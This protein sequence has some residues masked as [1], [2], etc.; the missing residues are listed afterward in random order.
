MPNFMVLFERHP[1]SPL[2]DFPQSIEKAV[3]LCALCGLATLVLF[4]IGVVVIVLAERD[5][6][7]YRLLLL[8][9]RK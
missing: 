6:D 9:G 7:A 1:P 2:S 3:F 8:V 4:L 5:H